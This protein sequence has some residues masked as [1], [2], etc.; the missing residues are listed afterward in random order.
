FDSMVGNLLKKKFPYITFQ[1]VQF[2][3]GS[4]L[5]DLINQNKVPDILEGNGEVQTWNDLGLAYDLAPMIAKY[6]T[7]LNRFN[8]PFLENIR[9]A[10]PAQKETIYAMPY[11]TF[12]LVLFYNKDIFDKF[13]VKYPTDGM[14]WDQVYNLAKQVTKNDGGVQYR[15]LQPDD[16]SRLA[17]EYPLET[18]DPNTDQPVV[19]ND[20]W[21]KF[22]NFFR[23]IYQIPGNLDPK[24]LTSDYAGFLTDKNVAMWTFGT[25]HWD[26]F[27]AATKNGLHWDMVSYPQF[28][29]IPGQGPAQYGLYFGISSSSNY[30]DQA[31][32]VLSYI[33]SD[34]VQTFL[35]RNGYS[36]ALASPTVSKD[37]GA[38]MPTLQGKNSKATYALKNALNPKVVSKYESVTGKILGTHV[39]DMIT[40][41][42]DVNTMLR[43]ATDEMT[44]AIQTAKQSGQ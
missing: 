42:K 9:R 29:D 17:R 25:D 43:E 28:S 38:D 13:G 40:N 36:P 14:T 1:Y 8:Q 19:Q 39:K 18:L 21:T 31:F 27:D 16:F 20:Q 44:K 10:D 41:G 3:T 30:K 7:D 26:Q 11:Y 5:P 34:E 4:Q 23:S 32:R 22:F 24:H 12:Q 37:Y 15:G 35:A 6:K 2:Q 33:D